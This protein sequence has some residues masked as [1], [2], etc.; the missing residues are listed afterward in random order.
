MSTRI[1]EVRL[2]LVWFER[3]NGVDFK[4]PFALDCL[5]TV[6]GYSAEFDSALKDTVLGPQ[7]GQ[8]IPAARLEPEALTPPWP[9]KGKRHKHWFW[10][11]YLGKEPELLDGRFAFTKL[12]PFH[13]G[14][15]ADYKAKSQGLRLI[16]DG[17]L[18]PHGIGLVL[19]LVLDLDHKPWPTG[20]VQTGVAAGQLIQSYYEE[21]FQV[22]WQGGAAEDQT[23]TQ[24]RRDCW[25]PC[26]NARLERGANAGSGV[27]DLSVWR[28]WCVGI[29]TM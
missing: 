20:G 14:F 1:R 28:R 15:P 5:R 4:Q 21:M 22:S 25:N 24:R 26:G 11:Y 18:Y 19:T 2:S 29:S 10:I 6:D 23:A 9:V 8:E 27:R 12:T 16:A 13:T 7:A 17:Y 3:W